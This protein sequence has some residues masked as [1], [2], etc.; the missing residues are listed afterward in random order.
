VQGVFAALHGTGHSFEGAGIR[1]V[2]AVVGMCTHIKLHVFT[3][4]ILHMH[5]HVRHVLVSIIRK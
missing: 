5:I 1:Y 4:L 3:R 2:V